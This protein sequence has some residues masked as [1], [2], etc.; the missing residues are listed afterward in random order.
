MLIQ[1]QHCGALL[2]R[3]AAAGCVRECCPSLGRW[4]AEAVVVMQP[5]V[6]AYQYLVDGKWLTSPDAPIAHDEEDHLCNKVGWPAVLHAGIPACV[7]KLPGP[8]RWRGRL[9]VYGQRGWILEAGA[10]I[11]Q[12]R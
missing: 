11:S 9:L 2:E 10:S 8:G 7:H 3:W 4:H 12:A 5:G 6:Y 1:W